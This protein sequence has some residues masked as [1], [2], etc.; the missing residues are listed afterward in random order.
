MW[1]S[2]VTER[3]L[4]AGLLVHLGFNAEIYRFF[5]DLSAEARDA[6]ERWTLVPLWALV[7]W[8]VLSGRLRRPVHE[9]QVGGR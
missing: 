9:K 2:L 1:L 8:L 5:F 4:L 7:G 3:P 6:V